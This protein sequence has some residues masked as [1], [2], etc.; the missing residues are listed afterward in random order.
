MNSIFW[1]RKC[2]SCLVIWNISGKEYLL[3][4]N[5]QLKFVNYDGQFQIREKFK[6]AVK[7]KHLTSMLFIDIILRGI[8]WN[9]LKSK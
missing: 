8:F 2:A 1:K 3:T 4:S 6:I 9:L 7:S 5:G